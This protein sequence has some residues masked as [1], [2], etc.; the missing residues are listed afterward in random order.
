MFDLET[1]QKWF[2]ESAMG[3]QMARERQEAKSAQRRP[4]IE[5]I[6]RLEA[7][8]EKGAP[9]QAAAVKTAKEKLT[10]AEN[11]LRIERE[12]YNR[13]F[14]AA[15]SFTVSREGQI[16]QHRRALQESAD[17]EAINSFRDRLIAEQQSIRDNGLDILRGCEYVHRARREIAVSNSVAFAARVRKISDIITSVP[18]LAYID[19]A[20]LPAK[21]QELLDS[22]PAYREV[23]DDAKLAKQIQEA[24]VVQAK[25]AELATI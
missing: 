3:Q 17:H 20:E 9:K 8:L 14:G 13:E 7:E 19:E 1:I 11:A 24:S 23:W 5:A 22:L 10:A 18:A 6:R 21:M 15:Q 2:T 25:D 16:N 12:N 4:H